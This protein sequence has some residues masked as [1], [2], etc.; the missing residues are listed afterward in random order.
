[1][2]FSVFIAI[3]FSIAF[4]NIFSAAMIYRFVVLPC[5]EVNGFYAEAESNR[6][7]EYRQVLRA[8]NILRRKHRLKYFLVKW[9][10]HFEKGAI[11]N[12]GRTC[13]SWGGYSLIVFSVV[14]FLY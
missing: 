3:Y 7:R 8:K 4:A 12:H 2:S 11:I 13:I 5:L 1:M 6:L 10:V 9:L 14:Y